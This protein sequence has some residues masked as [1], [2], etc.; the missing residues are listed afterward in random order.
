VEKTEIVRQSHDDV[1]K[2][3]ARSKGFGRTL[4]VDIP[5]R[6]KGVYAVGVVMAS[7]IPWMIGMIR[8]ILISESRTVLR[9]TSIWHTD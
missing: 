5:C 4:G 6:A 2:E 8:H 3:L 1:I 9:T 7:N